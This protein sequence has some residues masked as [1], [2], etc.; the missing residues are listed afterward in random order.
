MEPLRICV[1]QYMKNRKTVSQHIFGGKQ[2]IAMEGFPSHD[3]CFISCS[4]RGAAL[5]FNVFAAVYSTTEKW[6]GTRRLKDEE[7]LHSVILK[8]FIQTFCARRRA[9]THDNS[10][11]FPVRLDS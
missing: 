8:W 3:D 2:T 10:I 5:S 7:I 9:D 6:G 11:F 4:I 1:I